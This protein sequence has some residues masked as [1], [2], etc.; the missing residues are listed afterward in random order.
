MSWDTCYPGDSYLFWCLINIFFI[1][2]LKHLVVAN[3]GLDNNVSLGDL[4]GAFR[5]YGD[6]VDVVM[7][8]QKSYAFVSMSSER[9]AEAAYAGL[10]GR[11]LVRAQNGAALPDVIL[12]LDYVDLGRMFC[13]HCIIT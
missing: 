5:V 3:G 13:S 6:V 8:P 11:P 10:N 4:Q 2:I 1:S 9:H 12:Y 7:Q